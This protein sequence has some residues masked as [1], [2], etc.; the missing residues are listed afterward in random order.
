MNRCIELALKGERNVS[1]NPMVG[2]VIV[3]DGNVIGEGYHTLYG[4]AHAEV[5]AVNSVADQKLLKKA[6][7]YVNL[8]PCSHHGKTPPCADLIIEKGFKEVIIGTVDPNPLVCGKGIEKLKNAGIA[9]MYGI[10]EAACRELNRRFFTFQEKKRP[11]VILKWAQTA[12]GFIDT[13]RTEGSDAKPLQI[14]GEASRKLLH[15]WRSEEQAIMVGTNTALLDNPRLTVREVEGKNPIRITIDK[16]LRIPKHFHLFDGSVPTLVFTG[17]R[18][19]S[20]TNLEYIQI[21][22]EKDIVPQV[23]DVLYQ[24]NIRSVLVEGGEQ[25]LTGFLKYGSWDEARV[26]QSQQKLLKGV[27]A[28]ALSMAGKEETAVGADILKVYRNK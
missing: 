8:E 28:P 15:Q 3:L 21:D 18:E 13:K 7:L 12:D 16:W 25:L 23:L 2:S 1:P 14:S 19:T 24:K 11:Y 9:V 20:S 27:S 10:N 5:N 22:A 26:F 6:T 17:L 4:Q